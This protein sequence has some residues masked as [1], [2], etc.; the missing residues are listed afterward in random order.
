M[1]LRCYASKS[2]SLFQ[3]SSV[4][5]LVAQGVRHTSSFFHVRSSRYLIRPLLLQLG[6]DVLAKLEFLVLHYQ[7]R[8]TL[9]PNYTPYSILFRTWS[10]RYFIKKI[11]NSWFSKMGVKSF[12]I[13]LKLKETYQKVKVI[14]FFSQTSKMF[15]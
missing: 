9:R 10:E 15:F 2:E 7:N 14:P 11:F 13:R 6:S 3:A 4:S 5:F 1:Q 8:D 12:F